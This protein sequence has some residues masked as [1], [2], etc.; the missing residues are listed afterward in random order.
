MHRKTV[1]VQQLLTTHEVMQWL[2]VSRH[3]LGKLIAEDGLPVIKLGYRTLRFDPDA[4]K[5]W[6]ERRQTDEGV[7]ERISRKFGMQV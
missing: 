1:P 4:V 5:R 6:L 3:E 7:R 2:R